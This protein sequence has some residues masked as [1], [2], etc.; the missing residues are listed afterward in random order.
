MNEVQTVVFNLFENFINVC[1]KLE[2]KYFLV[3][4]TALGAKK[5][6]GFIPWDDDMDVAMP[7]KDYEIFLEKA[8][9]L[10]PENIFV[11][12]YRTDKSFPFLYT[13]LR[14]SDTAFIEKS[15]AHLPMNHGI[16]LDVFPLDSCTE[17][18]LNSKIRQLKIK[19]GFWI[20]FCVLDD[21]SKKKIIFRNSILKTLG[22]DKKTDKY[23]KKLEKYV[24]CNNEKSEYLCNYSDRQG[25][26][27]VLREWYGEGQAVNF[28]GKTAFIPE[29]YEKYFSNKYGDWRSELPADKQKSHHKAMIVDVL[30]SYKEF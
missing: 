22:F 26:G 13:K 30:K 19:L 5:Y 23:L 18:Q 10:L 9:T 20:P 15:V 27:A 1:D 4:G 11:Q 7:R 21:K 14:A 25:K 17:K 3:N 6:S 16:Y 29:Q 2:L 24:S 12:N 8:Q 28:E